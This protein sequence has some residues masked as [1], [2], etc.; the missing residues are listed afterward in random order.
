MLTQGDA[1]RAK[2]FANGWIAAN[3]RDTAFRLYLAAQAMDTKDY[4]AAAAH[5]RAVLALSPDNVAALNNLAWVGGQ[6][7]DPNA[8]GYAERAHSL[9]PRSVAVLDTLGWLHIRRGN[10]SKGIELLREALRLAP[11]ADGVRINLAKALL[12]A[13]DK[14]AAR[15]ELEV[16]VKREGNAGEAKAEAQA[17]VNSL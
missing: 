13:G 12:Q 3:P 11:D 4:P 14:Q 7:N 1:Q 5:Y 16:V 8:L 15:Q 10:S 6:L 9:A 17:L 2:E